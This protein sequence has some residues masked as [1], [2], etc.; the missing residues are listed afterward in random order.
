MQTATL[1]CRLGAV[2][3]DAFLRCSDADREHAAGL[4][5]DAVGEGRLAID[6]LDQRLDQVFH[7]RTYGD[8][9]R[10]MGDLPA[11]QAFRTPAP[12]PP[13]VAVP[14]PPRRRRRPLRVWVYALLLWW[15][16]WGALAHAASGATFAALAPL[17][18]LTIWGYV[19][20]G[21]RSRLGP[22]RQRHLPPPPP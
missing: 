17:L 20:L 2:P 19:L 12:L 13:A 16:V 6:E 15:L 1:G 7:A 22:R 14:N 11:W 10:A 3:A 9:D 4:V 8:L 18:F 21:R 5:R